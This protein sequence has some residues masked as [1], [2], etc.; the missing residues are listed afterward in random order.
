[1]SML[2]N[3]ETTQ[4]GVSFETKKFAEPGLT[5]LTRKYL[6]IRF[7]STVLYPIISVIIL[8]TLLGGLQMLEAQQASPTAVLV[9]Q[10]AATY[11]TGVATQFT[12]SGNSLA[13]DSALNFAPAG[14]MI[15]IPP[16]Y[17]EPA[18][19]QT[20]IVSR[21]N[22][23]IQCASTDAVTFSA[24]ASSVIMFSFQNSGSMI[25]CNLSGRRSASSYGDVIAVSLDPS[26]TSF[27][28]ENNVIQDIYGRGLSIRGCSAKCTVRGNQFLNFGNG[29]TSGDSQSIVVSDFGTL[30]I[31]RN[32]F[33]INTTSDLI[34]AT[35]VAASH[36]K[37]DSHLIVT[38]NTGDQYYRYAFEVQLSEGDVASSNN[39]WGEPGTN[40][41]CMSI[42]TQQPAANPSG[43]VI[44][45][46]ST[47]IGDTCYKPGG[48]NG[49]YSPYSGCF[50][51]FSVNAT[52]FKCIGHWNSGLVIAG[53]NVHI[54]HYYSQYNEQ[55][56]TT[57]GVAGGVAHGLHLTNSI[58]SEPHLAAVNV[59]AYN[60][61]ED[62]LFSNVEVDITPYSW[63][64]YPSAILAGF[65]FG[66]PSN[67]SL[68]IT[69][70]TVLLKAGPRGA[71]MSYFGF[72]AT[73]NMPDSVFDGLNVKNEDVTPIGSGFVENGPGQ[74][75]NT[76]ITNS[77]YMNLLA[78]S[79]FRAD[80]SIAYCDNQ[81]LS[82]SGSGTPVTDIIV[83]GCKTPPK[84]FTAAPASNGGSVVLIDPLA[85]GLSQVIDMPT[86]GS[87]LL[88]VPSGNPPAAG[89]KLQLIIRRSGGSAW[90][91]ASTYSAGQVG[92]GT[93]GHAYA[94]LLGSN[95]N[96]NPVT[97]IVRTYWNQV[98]FHAPLFAGGAEGFAPMLSTISATLAANTQDTM[99]FTYHGAGTSITLDTMS[100]GGLRGSR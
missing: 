45:N 39:F 48:M 18:I 63:P 37:S 29:T 73:G 33:H 12:T 70:S 35:N 93:N 60:D 10:N 59:C 51:N 50:E 72:F 78:V 89:T 61:C 100:T 85:N 58:I 84:Y 24:G 44:T 91:A 98:W 4:P 14:S 69:K 75:N 87:D 97:D 83:Q 96:H 1:M 53:P 42:G 95:T 77:T 40:G 27:D 36:P 52:G 34:Y 90:N 30:E 17:T 81:S 74:M 32:V 49:S 16:G 9:Y 6:Y 66:G 13:L 8:N 55:G 64:S 80:E 94:S 21:A 28:F 19:T 26:V 56:V 46:T 25:G 57:E 22:I 76:S 23:S 88:L 2:K 7:F 67:S 71:G 20:H 54:D 38:N 5:S 99:I 86:D 79:N 3:K 11:V 43:Y 41:I 92:T 68:R 47:S 65:A 15:F 82:G 62:D 31:D